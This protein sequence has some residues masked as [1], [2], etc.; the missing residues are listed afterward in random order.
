L[1]RFVEVVAVARRTRSRCGEF[2]A[3]VVLVFATMGLTHSTASR[4]YLSWIGTRPERQG[5]GLGSLLLRQ[6]L[7]R[8]A[9]VDASV[10]RNRTLY[11][12]HG[13]RVNHEHGL[14]GGPTF[15]GMWRDPRRPADS[16]PC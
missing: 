3:R 8:S 13:F 14:P 10:P 1:S 7:A 6:G 11:E 4:L 5:E 9:Y 16:L 15:L 12:R 2:A